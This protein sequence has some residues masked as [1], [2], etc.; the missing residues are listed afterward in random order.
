SGRDGN[1]DGFFSPLYSRGREVIGGI[2]FL[3]ETTERRR[4]EDA[5]RQSQKMEAVGQLTGGIAHDFN[6]M[7]TV[8]AGNLELLEGKLGDEPRLLRLVTSAALA[9]SRAEKLTQQLLTFSRRQQLRSQPI[10]F[11]QIVI[12]MDDLL[13]R[14]VGE[15]IEIRKQ[16]AAE[17]WPALADP[18]QIETALL[19]LILNARDAMPSGG[20]ITIETG[21][22][23]VAAGHREFSPGAYAVLSVTDTGQGMSD[24]VLAHV[25]EPFF[26]TKE[27]GKGTG[28]GLSQV[29]GFVKQSAGHVKVDSRVG[30]GTTV[31][32]YLPRAEGV[33]G[34]AEGTPMREQQY[35]GSEC[36]LVVEDDHGVRDFAVSVLRELGYQVLEAANGDAALDLLG[37]TPDVDLLFT[38]VVMPGA[39]SGADL[40]RAAL[41]RRPELR[42]L[43]TSGY[44]TRL[45]EKEWPDRRLELLRKPYRSI[46]LAERVRAVLNGA[47]TAA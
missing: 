4:I 11:N 2:G 38:D 32:L 24:E 21:N 47:P 42:V 28:L 19:N 40:A 33:V 31:R 34:T 46:D 25:F 29:Y 45:V 3:R 7:L 15:H 13:H 37:G 27:V 44:T 6:N 9:A 20:H 17:L 18:N 35:R 8:I 14:T 10:D 36:V 23:E 39:L 43:F 1:Y 41:E 5:L 16:L 26:T 22:T 30:G 12:G